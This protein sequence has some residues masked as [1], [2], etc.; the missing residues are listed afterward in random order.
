MPRGT[1]AGIPAGTCGLLQRWTSRSRE[2]A[3]ARDLFRDS[4]AIAQRLAAREAGSATAR[5][6]VSKAHMR[7][8]NALH[9]LGDYPAALIEVSAA[10]AIRAE[11]VQAEPASIGQKREL[12]VCHHLEG[13]I[14]LAQEK[15]SEALASFDRGRALY[16]RRIGQLDLSC[17]HCHESNWGRR[18]L[19]E[20]IS[21]GHGTAYPI[22]RLEWQ[23]AGSLHRR[24]RSCLNGVRAEMLPYG[25]PGFLDLELFL[26]WRAKGLAIETPGVRR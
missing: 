24:F 2:Q 20:T 18:L 10:T 14:L 3:R 23:A 1:R 16:Y 17:A 9:D 13:T 22:Y 15:F 12:A 21:Q 6:A 8:A 26:A 11:L 7:L 4:L 25:S 19:A 5:A